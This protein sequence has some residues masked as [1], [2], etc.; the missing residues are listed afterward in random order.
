MRIVL[1]S[2]A[3]KVG[4]Q[5][6]K[7]TKLLCVPSGKLCNF[8]VNAFPIMHEVGKMVIIKFLSHESADIIKLNSA[9]KCFKNFWAQSKLQ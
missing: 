7:S 2:Q 4:A 9:L 1:N 8:S 5:A 3:L 6:P